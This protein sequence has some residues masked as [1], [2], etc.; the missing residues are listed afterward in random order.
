MCLCQ[1]QGGIVASPTR[2]AGRAAEPPRP[3]GHLQK[4]RKP[5]KSA[6]GRPHASTCVLIL[7]D[8]RPLRAPRGHRALPLLFGQPLG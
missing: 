8:G 5:R 3:K 2:L 7:C 4:H 6:A 1:V